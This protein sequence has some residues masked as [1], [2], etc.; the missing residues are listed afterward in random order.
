ML[1]FTQKTSTRL[2]AGSSSRAQKKQP[3][4]G[5]VILVDAQGLYIP[6]TL[7][8]MGPFPHAT[9]LRALRFVKSAIVSNPRRVHPHGLLRVLRPAHKKTTA[10]RR[11]YFGGRAGTRTLDPLIKSQLLYQLSYASISEFFHRTVTII[12]F[13]LSNA[14]FYRNAPLTYVILHFLYL[15][16]F[17]SL[18]TT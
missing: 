18:P 13:F 7:S 4:F 6:I 5:G 17:V 2:T 9:I 8:L 10:I 12:D 15:K 11:C 14:S 3:P 1:F 16:Y